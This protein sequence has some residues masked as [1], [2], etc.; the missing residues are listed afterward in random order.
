MKKL[1]YK[2]AK[3]I[4]EN[5][6]CK[7][8]SNK[9]INAM[10]KLEYKCSCGNI[11][12]I[13]LHS[14]KNGHRCM[15]CSHKKIAGKLSHNIEYVTSFFNK[16]GC[17]LLSNN[18]KNVNTKLKF[19]CNCGNI[20]VNTFQKFK[21][22][23]RC[24]KCG[25]KKRNDKLKHSYEYIKNYFSKKGCKLLSD[26]YI[27]DSIP[28]NYIC[29]CGNESRITFNS[30]HNG[31]KCNKCGIKR[32]MGKNS[33]HWNHNLTDDDRRN[34][35][36][37]RFVMGYTQWVKDVYKKDKWTCQKCG[38]IGKE[39]NAHHIENYSTN[40]DLRLIK[41]NGITLCKKCHNKFHKKYGIKNNNSNQIEEFK[42]LNDDSLIV[43][44]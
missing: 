8:L 33:V 18:Y 9:Y 12:K 11:S 24:Y 31:S 44:V 17:I 43:S 25:N 19:I 4:F 26:K 40:K 21:G 7:L 38:R 13:L 10:T 6:G 23:R 5:G 32:T 15:K 20:A 2:E 28:L 27:N 37:R 42:V 1:T 29:S 16:E 14:F 34:M 41:S 36:D 39:L 30:L 35:K 22:G 3:G